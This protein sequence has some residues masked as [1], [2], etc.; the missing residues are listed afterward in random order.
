M[1]LTKY[2]LKNGLN[3]ILVPSKK[4]PVVSAQMWVR[5]GSADEELSVAGVSHFIEHLLFKGTDKYKPGEIASIVE[6]AGGELNAYTSFDQTV[7]YVTLPSQQVELSLDI[8]SQMMG[9]PTFDKTEIDRERE[10]VIEE[11]KKG[12][13]SPGRVSSQLMFATAYSKHAY[14][15]PVIGYEKV[16]KSIS[17]K[18]IKKYFHDHYCAKNMFLVI[19]GDIDLPTIK[20]QIKLFF[21]QWSSHSPKLS[22]RIPEPKKNQPKMI[23]QKTSFHQTHVSLTWKIPN[24]KHR[25]I[26]ALDVLAFAL[27]QGESSRL[28]QRLRI[29]N[30]LVNSIGASAFTP[31][32]Q[33]LFIISFTAD[34]KDV[35]KVLQHLADEM[36]KILLNGISAEELKKAITCMT[37]DQIYSQETVDGL[38][39]SFGSMEFYYQDPNA[40]KKYLLSLKK[41]TLTDIEKKTQ[42]YLKPELMTI[43]GLVPGKTDVL[44]KDLRHFKKDIVS[45]LKMKFREKKKKAQKPAS[46]RISTVLKYGKNMGSAEGKVTS[47]AMANGARLILVPTADTP[48]VSL[49]VGFGGGLHIEPDMKEGLSE[50]YSRVWGA[51]NKNMN[52]VE[53]MHAVDQAAASFSTF[54]GRNTV[55]FSADYLSGFD[56]IIWPIV[57]ESISDPLFPNDVL[58]REKIVLK[59]MLEARKDHPSTIC[60]RQFMS[61]LFKGHPYEKDQ[62]GTEESLKQINHAALLAMDSEVR[63]AANMTMAVVGD[64]DMKIWERRLKDLEVFL[65]RGKRLIKEISHRGPSSEIRQTFDMEKEQAHL[66]IGFKGVSLTDERRWA[67]Q[68][69]QS[70]LAGQGG[71]LFIE[72]RDKNS[73]AYSVSPLKMEGLGTGYFGVYIGCSPDKVPLAE[74][75]IWEELRKLQK[76]LIP[77]DEIDRAKRYLS[78]R[79]VIDLQHKSTICSSVLFD[80][81][82]GNDPAEGLHP[83]KKI[84][85]VTAEEVMNLAKYLFSQPPVVSLVGPRKQAVSK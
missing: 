56:E 61:A 71:R 10:V 13:D 19:S 72:L 23:I 64:I 39:R 57:R 4:A 11:I 55:G 40:Y 41:L 3:V 85:E 49:R 79:A 6:G 75:M 31:K 67:L 76:Q 73:L 59:K 62:I 12:M 5:T 37:S 82:Y 32:D 25:D 8:I 58:D 36:G 26:P 69:M 27:G 78:G 46:S 16:I 24:V 83:D 20:N 54:S 7:F 21:G 14:R 60:M 47:I 66:V 22:R 84:Q 30:P 74:K 2:Q 53:I 70:V 1:R 9:A 63:C 77:Q 81:I 68:V 17:I 80:T 33:G 45:S 52:E 50:L 38:S 44:K 48:T 51:G 34:E 43:S 15:R 35:S 65:P 29:E 28:V 42:K 18:K